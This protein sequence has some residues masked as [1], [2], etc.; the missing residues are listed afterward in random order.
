MRCAA[1]RAP[2]A[3]S[4]AA[5]AASARYVP[6]PSSAASAA[7]E[8]VSAAVSA[9]SSGTAA[10]QVELCLELAVRRRLLRARCLQGLERLRPTPARWQAPAVRHEPGGQRL[11]SDARGIIPGVGG[12]PCHHHNDAGGERD[13]QGGSGPAARRRPARP[14]TFQKVPELEIEIFVALHG[15]SLGRAAPAPIVHVG[16]GE[17]WDGIQT[18]FEELA[19]VDWNRSPSRVGSSWRGSSA[20]RSHGGRSSRRRTRRRASRWAT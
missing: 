13:R 6:S 12:M 3:A 7:S 17:V 14:E 19:S 9:I 1:A 5:A 8:A 18:F 20:G 10:R 11:G 4:T 15:G 2:A 16:V